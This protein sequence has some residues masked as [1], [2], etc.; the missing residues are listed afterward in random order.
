MHSLDCI[1]KLDTFYPLLSVLINVFLTEEITPLQKSFI[2][3]RSFSKNVST[4]SQNLYKKFLF[5]YKT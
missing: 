4:F 2:I 3:T 1:Q 5:L